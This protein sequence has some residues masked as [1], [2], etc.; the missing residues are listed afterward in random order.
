MKRRTPRDKPRTHRPDLLW[1]L[2]LTALAWLHRLAFMLSN[3]DRAWPF[4]IFYEGDAE[5]FYD[6]ARAILSG[7][8]YDAGIPFHPPAFP[9]LLAFIHSIVGAGAPDSSVPYIAVK[10][11]MAVFGSLPVG[12]IYLIVKP[13]LG[14]TVAL[15]TAGLC[16]YNF[17]L[18]IIG[19]SAVS[20]AFYLTLMLASLLWWSRRFPHPLAAAYTIKNFKTDGRRRGLL[21]EGFFL[22]ALLG[23][24]TLTRAEGLLVALIL[25][26]VGV[27]GAYGW[28]PDGKP[29]SLRPALLPWAMI[30]LGFL[31]ALTPWTLRNRSNLENFN[32]RNSRVM[33]EPLPTF[34]PLTTYGPINFALANNPK[35]D[36]GF[37]RAALPSNNNL[38]TLDLRDP[39]HLRFYR[40]GYSIGFEFMKDHP[41]DFLKLLLRK[42][43][44]YFEA[45]KLG[46]TQWDY[47]GGLTGLR[48][49]VDLFVPHS[50]AAVW[51]QIPWAVLGLALMLKLGVPAR[52]WAYC[53][54]LLTLAGLVVTGAYF[55][56]ARQGVLMLPL[57]FSCIALALV[58]LISRIIAW[59]GAF[60]GI[61][62]APAPRLL[63][64]LGVVA[65][66]LLLLEGWGATTD[67]NYIA[68]GT[69]LP[70]QTLL[71]R[72]AVLYLTPEE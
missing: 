28:K 43:G 41:G 71:N 26:G 32:R 67:R 15:V 53:I 49:P 47:P 17:G 13:Y 10:C 21:V 46:W 5:T 37:S 11:I 18:Y 23:L 29:R 34:V 42:W 16:L 66:L 70:G 64:I 1:F 51:L 12:L 33:A 7:S 56:Y 45:L 19:I 52:R 38:T 36:G 31:L 55:G 14:R 3:R 22:G 62:D 20:E 6:H 65:L 2:G 25:W 4:T 60:H 27:A 58:W 39:E 68:T 54:L 50:Y 48:R 30:A 59:R 69:T 44:L 72:D 35:A 9:H 63:R 24:M 57:W 8:L 61:P 40:H